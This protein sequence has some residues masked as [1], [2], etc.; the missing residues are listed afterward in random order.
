MGMSMFRGVVRSVVAFG[1]F[2]VVS[3]STRYTAAQEVAITFDDL[4]SHGPLPQR[5]DAREMWRAAMLSAF[6]D[7]KVPEVY[8]FINA[9]KTGRNSRGH[10]SAEDCGGRPGNRWGITR[11][12]TEL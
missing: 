12:T 9:G 1:C 11:T 2:A 4:P 6:K 10:G 5:N 8:G 7:A 3:C